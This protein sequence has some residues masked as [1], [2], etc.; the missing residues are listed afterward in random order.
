MNSIIDVAR[1]NFGWT[2][3]WLG[4][5]DSANEEIYVYTSS[6]LEIPLSFDNAIIVM[7]H[8]DCDLLYKSTQIFTVWNGVEVKFNCVCEPNIR[9]D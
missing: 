1:N 9:F 5:N 7:L 3:V 6:G 8:K 4:I 2:H